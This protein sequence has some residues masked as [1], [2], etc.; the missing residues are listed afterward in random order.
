MSIIVL[1]YASTACYQRCTDSQIGTYLLLML[2]ELWVQRVI[3]SSVVT[4]ILP[5][6]NRWCTT[7]ALKYAKVSTQE[8]LLLRGACL[9][10]LSISARYADM[11]APLVS[12]DIYSSKE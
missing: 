7:L 6:R 3:R 11:E 8:L 4:L 5:D 1:L 2:K 10:A 12:S 9:S